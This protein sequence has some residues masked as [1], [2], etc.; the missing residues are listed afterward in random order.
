M[1]IGNGNKNK[2]FAEKQKEKDFKMAK[3][4]LDCKHLE[5]EEKSVV[6]EMAKLERNLLTEYLMSFKQ[7]LLLQRELFSAGN[8]G[9][10]IRRLD[11]LLLHDRISVDAVSG[12]ISVSQNTN[13][14]EIDDTN[15]MHISCGSSATD[16]VS[17]TSQTSSVR[18]SLSMEKRFSTVR[19]SPS[20]IRPADYV[21]RPVACKPPVIK[22]SEI[23]V[24]KAPSVQ[25]YEDL[26]DEVSFYMT[27]KVALDGKY[28]SF[29]SIKNESI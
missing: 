16:G 7:I 25:Q 20:P 28:F 27:H 15:S 11:Q 23:I 9:Q 24:P 4:L 2:K 12:V 21:P 22:T 8:V 14:N 29:D 6:I 1:K 3:I 10:S 13:T 18:S 26:D 19:R 17:V 5:E